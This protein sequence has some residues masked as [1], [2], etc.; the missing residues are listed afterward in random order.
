MTAKIYC[1]YLILAAI[2]IAIA[3]VV[4]SNLP[5]DSP[6]DAQRAVPSTNGTSSK[7]TT[8]VR[9]DENRVLRMD[10]RSF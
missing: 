2:V 3:S 9:R 1:A 8:S 4:A 10:W 6:N 5:G 7:N